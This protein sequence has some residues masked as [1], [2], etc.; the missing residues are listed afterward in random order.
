MIPPLMSGDSLR[1][2]CA[3][4]LLAVL[5][6]FAGSHDVMAQTDS[7]A[8]FYK[9]RT[10]YVLAGDAVGGGFD[11]YARLVARHIGKYIPGNP[12]VVPENL[13]GGGSFLAGER[14]AVAAP[15]DGTYIGALHPTVF[16]DP[17][18]G[19]PRKKVKRLDL[20][21][22]GSASKNLSVCL[23]RTDAPVQSFAEVF[24]KE[25]IVGAGNDASTTREYAGLLKNLLG[26]KLKISSGY[27]GNADIYLAVDRNE[28]QGICGVG[29]IGVRAL[30]P[31]WF[32]KN[33]AAKIIAQESIHGE[34]DL[35]AMGV[36]RTLDFAKTD[37]QRQ[38]LTL[39]YSQQ[40]FGRPFVVSKK[41]PP[42]RL[43]ALQKAFMSVFSDPDFQ[44][45][46]KKTNLDVSPIPGA[47]V[48]S[49][50]NQAYAAPPDILAKLRKA[51]G[52]G[53]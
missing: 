18:M 14:I 11:A 30:R 47:E 45:D 33:G 10:V 40:E 8:S 31:N 21:Y 35:N 7:V 2:I 28:V 51:L 9:G 24:K 1:R 13:P 4:L 53:S 42:E 36:P 19:D 17:I 5:G 41:T 39:Y 37:D 44:I 50:V 34:P 15:E 32:K 6:A 25:L 23:A 26:A 48:E 27:T 46:A 20:A 38:I 22:L 12:N 29:S 43:A 16:L 49:L 52:Y 3:A